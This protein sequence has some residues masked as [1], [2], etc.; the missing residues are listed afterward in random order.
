MSDGQQP[1]CDRDLRTSRWIDS[2]VHAVAAA[3]AAATDEPE[4]A[5]AHRQRKRMRYDKASCTETKH[6]FLHPYAAA[7]TPPPPDCM[8]EM[9]QPLR[10]VHAQRV[11]PS[12][13]AFLPDDV[14]V[15][16]SRLQ[17]T[18][19]QELVLPHEVIESMHALAGDEVCDHHFRKDE[20][21]GAQATHAVLCQITNEAEQAVELEYHEAAWNNAIHSHLPRAVFASTIQQHPPQPAGPPTPRPYQLT[22]ARV[23]YA[24]SATIW[25]RYI[26]IKSTHANAVATGDDVSVSGSLVYSV[27]AV[28][29]SGIT[30]DSGSLVYLILRIF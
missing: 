28:S 12:P 23:A 15:L 25:G 7:H 5:S 8:S 3:T 14:K 27:S 19:R 6:T 13:A 30:E 2:L 21:A 4:G 26:P 16:H 17:K 1:F 11:L 22:S 9:S 20:T 18:R 10:S 29:D 24:M